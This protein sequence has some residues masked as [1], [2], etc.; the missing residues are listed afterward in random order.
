MRRLRTRLAG[1]LVSVLALA[2]TATGCRGGDASGG[3]ART[4][5]AAAVADRVEPLT[6][7]A[8]PRL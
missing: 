8:A 6:G 7:T 1:A 4:A 3:G 5:P 2:L